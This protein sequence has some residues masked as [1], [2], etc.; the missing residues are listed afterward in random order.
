MT[1]KI[2]VPRDS[3]ALSLGAD[4]V[5]LAVAGEA[6]RRG[7]NVEIVRNGS[8]GMFWLETMV[9][10]STSRGR[11]AYGPVDDLKM[12]RAVVLSSKVFSMVVSIDWALV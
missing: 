2:F 11:V 3:S 5:A 1:I 10:V 12:L 9:E 7:A 8:R 6:A 4:K